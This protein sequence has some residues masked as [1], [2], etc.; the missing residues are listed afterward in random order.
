VLNLW[1]PNEQTISFIRG[2][3]S[4]MIAEVGVYEGHTS[5]EIAKY[6]NGSGELHLFDFYDRVEEV[7]K[8][9]EADGFKN[10]RAFGSTYKLLDSY[11][12]HL[13]KLIQQHS[14][15]IYDY[16]YLDGAHTFPIDA[17]TFFLC[18][19]LLKLG[20]YIDFDDYDW[21]LAKSPSMNPE[22]FPLTAKC[23]TQ[24]QIEAHQVE[25]VINLAR[26]TGRY[27]EA[28]QN[29]IFRKEK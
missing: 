27:S 24:E 17:L 1:E 2:A 19:Q 8:K 28:V 12:W 26:H 15:P 13:A 20:G 16:I 6:L 25:M 9:I 21:T 10:V 3:N 22:K 11:N 7:R 14:A 4:K 29:K 18:D 23:Y 5:R